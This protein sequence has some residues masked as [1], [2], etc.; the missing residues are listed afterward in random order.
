[1]QQAEEAR[2]RFQREARSVARLSGVDDR[3]WLVTADGTVYGGGRAGLMG[4]VH[5]KRTGIVPDS[6]W[7][8]T[9][10]PGAASRL[11]IS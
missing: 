4:L 5:L 8:Y 3:I 2:R 10:S 11:P 7:V 1:M 9:V 6:S